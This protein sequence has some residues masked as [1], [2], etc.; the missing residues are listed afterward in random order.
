M[1]QS[2]RR[3]PEELR[4]P[5]ENNT[6]WLLRRVWDRVNEDNEHFMGVIVGQEGSGK[7]HT[8]IKM[9][10][11]LD[12]TFTADRVIFDVTDLLRVLKEGDHEP[13]NFYV[14]DEAGVQFGVRT[15]QER[16]QVL[17]NQALQLIR[18]HNLGL[19]FTV[20]AMS[21]LDSQTEKR[22]QAI[23]EMV[24]KKPGEFVEFKW[25]WLDVDRVKRNGDIYRS[26]PRRRDGRFL[27]RIQR[28]R[29][30]PPNDNLIEPYEATKSEFQDR[31]YEETIQKVDGEDEADSDEDDM[32]VKDIANQIKS[33]GVEA[34]ISEHG[35]TGEPYID[36]Q[37]IRVEY[38]TTHNDARAIKNLLE[39]DVDATEY[40][41]AI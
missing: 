37:M 11:K 16:G 14:L 35:R 32:T 2:K 28:F 38:E 1:S 17:A 18:S 15:W 31:M 9:A 7:S 39:R 20:P 30:S 4:A 34:V 12:E 13:G 40:K 5:N 6:R 41:E 19:V 36:S 8:A 33:D 22:L 21:D 23:V 26:Y 10:E 24:D 25:K 29:F 27:H 3:V